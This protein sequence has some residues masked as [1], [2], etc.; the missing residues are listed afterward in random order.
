MANNELEKYSEVD[1]AYLRYCPGSC[2]E[3]LRKSK[4]RIVI[5]LADIKAGHLPHISLQN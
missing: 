3:G 5:I 4:K 2:S 1:M